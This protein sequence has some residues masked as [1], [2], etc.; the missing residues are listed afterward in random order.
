[1]PLLAQHGTDLA[2]RMYEHVRLDC[3]DHQ[4]VVI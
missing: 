1:L 4:M 2:S 3:P